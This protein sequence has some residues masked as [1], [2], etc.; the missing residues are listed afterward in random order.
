MG[1]RIGWASRSETDWDAE[2]TT[3]FARTLP[4]WRRTA[5]A[6]DS[7]NQT[8]SESTSRSQMALDSA[9]QTAS[10]TTSLKA[11]K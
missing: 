7:Q 3:R 10:E 2:R 1:S 9:S 4:R 5:F 6:M 11:S 8:A